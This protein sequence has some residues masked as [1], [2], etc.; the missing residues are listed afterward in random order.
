MAD[1]ADDQL[2]RLAA[3]LAGARGD[4]FFPALAALL[5]D[6]LG[7]RDAR[8]CEAGPNHRART[9]GAWRDGAAVENFDYELAGMPCADVL[10][11]QIQSGALDRSR[12]PAA[13]AELGGY[14]GMPL[15]ANDGVA[16]GHLCAFATGPLTPSPRARA[17]CDIL[18]VRAAAELRLT[19][20][21]RERALLRGQKQRLIA[22]IVSNDALIGG[23]DTHR[24]LM[25][26]IRRASLTGAA[27]LVSGEPGTGKAIVARAIHAASA[28]AAKPFVV[29]DCASIAVEAELDVLPATLA[30]VSGG[31]LF[32]DE[33]GALAPDPQARLLAALAGV[34]ADVRVIASTNRNLQA[35]VS[36]GQFRDELYQRLAMFPIRVAPLR[37][38]VEDVAPLIDAFVRKHARRLG[39]TVNGIDPDSLSALQ[40]YS[41][42]GNVRE[43][44]YLVERAL[45]ISDTPLLKIDTDPL[46]NTSPAQRA[47][48][49]AATGS[50]PRPMPGSMELDDTMATGLHEV[51]RE[52][53]LRVLNATRWVIEGNAGAALKLG[54]K[55][56]TLRHRMKKLGI[57]RALNQPGARPSTEP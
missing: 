18:A 2:T 25:D 22:E 3:G 50:M 16:L 36:R 29:V 23:G 8:F 54:L 27:V 49:L 7:A 34:G 28:R 46:A 10:K 48:L 15:T 17:L 19:H 33:V 38:H 51:Q 31:T 13:P 24:R 4:G 1:D 43:L 5:G 9:L 21:K 42:P 56:A 57:S 12:F 32:L 55:P 53:I 39:R 52:H 6:L 20:V 14:F 37:A 26:E 35:A 44:E 30:L 41:W 11:G 47:A 40:R 45:V